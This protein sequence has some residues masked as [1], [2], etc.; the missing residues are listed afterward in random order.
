MPFSF[1]LV[2]LAAFSVGVVL[3][4]ASSKRYPGLTL[5]S[6][7]KKSRTLRI[8]ALLCLVLVAPPLA[9]Q[10]TDSICQALP[11]WL[12]GHASRATWIILGSLF[13]LLSGFAVFVVIRTSHAKRSRLALALGALNVA[14]FMAN[15][16]LNTGIADELSVKTTADGVILQSSSS[17]CAAATL[18]NVVAH[19][20]V[21]I[22]EPR[23]AR[24]LGTTSLG[25]SPGQMR[26]A[27]DQLGI[28]FV[29]LNER[30]REL[31]EVRPPAILFVDHPAVGPEGHAVAYFGT[32]KDRYEI[33]DPIYGRSFL[34][35][36][37]IHQ[38]WHGNGMTCLETTKGASP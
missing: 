23:A 5:E 21:E 6:S 2:Q 11:L 34:K 3:A 8:V 16:R 18:C 32:F 15:G 4:R 13:A 33:W 37:H 31:S 1:I 19:F 12:Q 30:F 38:V 24:L 10:V 14:L 25:T 35:S 20:G 26:Y 22:S 36:G 7:L 29:D 9:A 28:G 17:S 27:L